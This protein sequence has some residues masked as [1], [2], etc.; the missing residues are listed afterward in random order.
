MSARGITRRGSWV[1]SPSG[2]AASKPMNARRQKIMPWNAGLHAL[3]AGKEHAQR[4]LVGVHDE[5]R[6]D[7]QEDPISMTPSTMPA[8]VERPMPR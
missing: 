2:A 7:E 8:R 3:V 6:R 1:S 4:V 5:E